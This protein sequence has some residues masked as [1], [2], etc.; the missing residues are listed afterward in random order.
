MS[1]PFTSF[2]ELTTPG[3]YAMGEV[4]SALQKCIRRGLEDE[5]L[6]WATELD[7]AGYGE[8]AFKR[9]RIIASEDVGLGE[10]DACVVVR[11]LYENF[12][13]M[14]KKKDPNKP[15]RLFLVHAVMH[16]ARARKSRAVDNA[17]VHFYLGKRQ[18]REIPDFALDKHTRRG[19]QM[20]RGFGHFFA[21]GAIVENENYE[22]LDPYKQSARGTLVSKSAVPV[23]DEML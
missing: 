5:S 10:P 21:E 22:C 9:L 17:C 16:L 14:R 18:K 3:G 2:G 23:Q 13:E 19:R 1:K 11:S 8:Y 7:L 15:E 6:F 12:D 4:A 20:G